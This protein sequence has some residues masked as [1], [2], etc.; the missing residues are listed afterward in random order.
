MNVA[1][2]K[3]HVGDVLLVQLA[4]ESIVKTVTET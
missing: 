3:P 4:T 2:N 1:Y